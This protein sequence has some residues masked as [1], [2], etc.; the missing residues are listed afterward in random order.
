MKKMKRFAMQLLMA[1]FV[2]SMYNVQVFGQALA[3]E[4]QNTIGAGS[5]DGLEH[6]SQT[7][8]GGFILAGNTGS[9]EFLGDRTEPNV[10]L[11]DYWVVKLT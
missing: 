10:G 6:I 8:D 4:W 5:T 1:F 9:T 7:T 3:I 11:T 2:C